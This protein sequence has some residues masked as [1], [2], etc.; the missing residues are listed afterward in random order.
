MGDRRHHQLPAVCCTRDGTAAA[1]PVN[2]GNSL[3][4]YGVPSARS[5]ATRAKLCLAKTIVFP[6]ANFPWKIYGILEGDDTWTVSIDCGPDVH[7]SHSVSIPTAGIMPGMLSSG[8]LSWR[9]SLTIYKRDLRERR[10][11]TWTRS[12]RRFL[13]G[14]SG[15]RLTKAAPAE[16]NGAISTAAGASW[17]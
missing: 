13:V 9:Q 12:R 8:P 7:T 16:D 6:P 5:P 11:P 3:L 14:S 17:A 4:P 1:S 2:H 10:F 15:C